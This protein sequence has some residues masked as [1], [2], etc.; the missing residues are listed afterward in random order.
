MNEE[1]DKIDRL[2]KAG[3]FESLNEE[4][5]YWVRDNLGSA[6]AFNEL[7][8]TTMIAR[9]ERE[10]PVRSKVKKDLMRQFQEKHRPGWKLALQWKVP[11]YAVAIMLMIV[12]AAIVTFMPE[13]ERLV[14]TYNAQEPIIDTVYIAS[15]PDTVF[16][17]RTIERPVYVKVVAEAEEA[18]VLEVERK[19][20]GK[21]LADQSDIKDILVSG[22]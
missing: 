13:K 5:Q 6:E 20:R 2:L 8:E 10:M 15:Q 4:D 18:P 1:F 3:D 11:A 19:S 22:R 16:I 7:R 21:S 17:E 14:E 9:N 12:S